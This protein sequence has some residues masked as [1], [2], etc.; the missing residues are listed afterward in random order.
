MF[1]LKLCAYSFIATFLDFWILI[2][3]GILFFSNL[4]IC[5]LFFTPYPPLPEESPPKEVDSV[6]DNEE[7]ESNGHYETDSIGWNK[8]IVISPGQK[9][10]T[11]REH[12]DER[13]GRHTRSC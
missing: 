9:L 12:G 2:P 13:Q 10:G 11:G 4:C 1:V 5:G 7:I 6:E 3:L 8:N